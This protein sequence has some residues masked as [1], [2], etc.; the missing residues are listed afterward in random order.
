MNKE[1]LRARFRELER[2]RSPEQV[3]SA[4]RAVC[5]ALSNLPLFRQARCIG[6]YLSLP[7][8]IGTGEILEAAW[9]QGATVC[10]PYFRPESGDYGLSRL[11]RDSPL[12]EGRW[13]LREPEH[14]EPMDPPQL[15]LILVPGVAFDRQ[16][17]RLGHGGGHYDRLLVRVARPLRLGLAFQDQVVDH[18]PEEDH[19]QG[20]Q[21]ILT[22]QG[23]IEGNP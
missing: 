12:R 17:G 15:D 21:A 9:R 20:V 3:A 2:Q 1:E 18:L 4:S 23:L 11:D 14:P 7:T 10:V 13:H 16:G 8:E 6:A 5:E 19:D 22:D